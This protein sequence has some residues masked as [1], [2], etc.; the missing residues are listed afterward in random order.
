MKNI[1]RPTSEPIFVCLKVC[2]EFARKSLLW[3][4]FG[5]D[6]LLCYVCKLVNCNVF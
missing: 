4:S 6:I 3:L 5:L 2:Y 1:M